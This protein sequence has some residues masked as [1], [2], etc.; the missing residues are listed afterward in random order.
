QAGLIVEDGFGDAADFAGDNGDGAGAGFDGGDA[1]GLGFVDA[2]HDH[3]V[4][5]ADE[6]GDFGV[7]DPAEDLDCVLELELVDAILQLLVRGGGDEAAFGEDFFE[8]HFGAGV[9]AGV[10]NHVLA[11]GG[12]DH[13]DVDA[14]PVKR[15]A[16][17]GDEVKMNQLGIELTNELLEGGI[18][19]EHSYF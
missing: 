4:K 15:A 7:I 1:E 13:G 17:S 16:A 19:E 8:A 10:E 14:V 12:G 9:G 18:V 5:G 2:R 11:P 3:D 6:V